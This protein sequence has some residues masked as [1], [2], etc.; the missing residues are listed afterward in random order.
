MEFERIQLWKNGTD[1]TTLDRVLD[2]GGG[3]RP[4]M[5]V[6]PGGGYAC[7]CYDWEGTP[8]AE[9][10]VELGFRCFILRYRCAPHRFPEPQQDALRAMK[11]IR[12]NA[13]KWGVYADNIAAVGFSAGGHLAGCLGTIARGLSA[14]NGDEF[15]AVD[16]V[17]NGLILSYAVVTGGPKCHKGSVVNLMGDYEEKSIQAFS[18]ELHV[19]A[20]TPPT[21]LWSTQEDTAVPPENSEGFAAAM[22]KAGRPCELHVFPHGVHGSQLGKGRQDIPCWPAEAARFLR[23]SAGFR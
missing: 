20:G 13:E 23:E 6:I 7:V 5:L 2:G 18:L 19:D 10:F 9:R 14:E 3:V 22:R 21:Y 1:E 8:I 12:G 4:G 15:D 16:P 11:L 17:P